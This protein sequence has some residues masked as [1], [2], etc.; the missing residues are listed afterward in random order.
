MKKELVLALA[1]FLGSCPAAVAGL[2]PNAQIEKTITQLEES[3]QRG[4]DFVCE[5][6]DGSPTYLVLMASAVAFGKERLE[7]AVFLF[8]AGM[9][10][11]R[12]DLAAFP[13]N[14]DDED[15]DKMI[16]SATAIMAPRLVPLLL[17][18]GDLLPKVVTRL[19]RCN[20]TP[21]PGYDPGWTSDDKPTSEKIGHVVQEVK[22]HYD[23]Y[24]H[25]VAVFARHP[26]YAENVRI[27]AAALRTEAAGG[28]VDMERVRKAQQTIVEIK[29]HSGMQK[30]GA[31]GE[32][33]VEI[34]EFSLSPLEGVDV[35]RR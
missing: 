24:F 33:R 4:V 27:I 28:N 13:P 6:L 34:D 25:D 12:I 17:E 3:D 9:L 14:E 31:G 11:L 15:R 7:D 21:P 2:L 16:M 10:R 18:H 35:P 22:G 32:D 1:L 30:G 5:N 26:A 19:E 20:L 8:F 29:R 23:R